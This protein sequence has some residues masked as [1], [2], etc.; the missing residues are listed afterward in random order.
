MIKRILTATAIL[1]LTCSCSSGNADTL[2]DSWRDQQRLPADVTEVCEQTLISLPDTDLDGQHYD[3]CYTLDDIGR[4]VD[5]ISIDTDFSVSSKTYIYQG[6][7]VMPDSCVVEDGNGVEERRAVPRG[8][9]IQQDADDYSIAWTYDDKGKVTQSR[10]TYKATGK[11]TMQLD[12]EYNDRGE[13]IRETDTSY[14]ETTIWT[15]VYSYAPDGDYWLTRQ[16]YESR[17]DGP[18]E[19][20]ET[21]T[22]TLKRK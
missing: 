8:Q 10:Y 22:R 13:L 11:V 6:D 5:E 9:Q 18:R 15:Y 17:Q 21:T 19:L 2:S 4:V 7:N 16:K 1:L 20:R 3:V 14:G 12:S